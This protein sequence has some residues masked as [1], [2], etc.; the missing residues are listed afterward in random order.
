[1]SFVQ[2][3]PPSVD[4]KI[5]PLGPPERN[6]WGIRILSQNAAYRTFGSLGSIF[7]S[8]APVRPSSGRPVAR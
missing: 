5:P 7:R 2:L 8:E 4:L 3:S 6:L 1:M